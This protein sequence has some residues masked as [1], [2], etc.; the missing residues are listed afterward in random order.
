MSFYAPPH[1]VKPQQRSAESFSVADNKRNFFA[2]FHMRI[3]VRIDF[4]AETIS[5]P[6][7][8]VFSLSASSQSDTFPHEGP[9]VAL[10]G[11]TI[12]LPNVTGSTFSF[13]AAR[14]YTVEGIERTCYAWRPTTIISFYSDELHNFLFCIITVMKKLFPELLEFLIPSISE[15]TPPYSLENG[16]LIG[17]W[18]LRTFCRKMYEKLD[19]FIY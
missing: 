7:V 17:V 3:I 19:A 5:R 18:I 10:T 14:S 13:D 6:Y 2:S 8:S 4:I 15:L 16:A 1:H 9:T 12:S 11:T